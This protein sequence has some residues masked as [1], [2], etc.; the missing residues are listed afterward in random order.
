M[1]LI[2]YNL[3]CFKTSSIC[4]NTFSGGIPASVKYSNATGRRM[5][6][7]P[8]FLKSLKSVVVRGFLLKTFLFQVCSNHETLTPLPKLC[9]RLKA[10][11]LSVN[12]VG[13]LF[14]QVHCTIIINII[15]SRFISSFENAFLKA[16]FFN[17]LIVIK[18]RSY[19]Y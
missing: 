17:I 6:L 2:P 5:L 9:A 14:A 16:V 12:G 10:I 8:S 18:S 11:C 3:H 4:A 1:S 19:L 15:I 7:K 13:L